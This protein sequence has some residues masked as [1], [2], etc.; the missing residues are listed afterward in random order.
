MNG[1][2]NISLKEV[3]AFK[4]DKVIVSQAGS[5]DEETSNPLGVKY[6]AP[7]DL[8]TGLIFVLDKKIV[9]EEAIPYQTGHTSNVQIFLGKNAKDPNCVAL[10]YDDA[11]L[12]GSKEELD[13]VTYYSINI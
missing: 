8:M 13:G 10:T 3:S 11:V 6:E 2:C 1:D 12:K 5:S 9:H 7:M 4:W